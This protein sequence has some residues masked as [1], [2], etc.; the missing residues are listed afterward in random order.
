MAAGLV[1][2]RRELDRWRNVARG[3][4]RRGGSGGAR[5]LGRSVVAFHYRFHLIVSL[6]RTIDLHMC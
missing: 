1:I 3:S 5:L 4:P 6:E 2:V